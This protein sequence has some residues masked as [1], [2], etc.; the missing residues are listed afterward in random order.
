MDHIHTC[1]VGAG[2]VGLAIARKLASLGNEVVVLDAEQHYGQ[3]VS[4]RN[5]EVIHAGIYY[6]KDSSKA[7]FCVAGKELLYDYCAS[8]G[9]AADRCGKIIVATSSVE[10]AELETIALKARDNG[11]TD[12]EVWSAE[13]IRQEEPQVNATIGLH[14][15][16]SGIVDT[17]GLMSAM[18]GDLENS[19]GM[20]VG[21]TR[22]EAVD[23]PQDGFIVQSRVAGDE[24]RFSCRLLVNA[25]GLGAQAVAAGIEGLDP[26]T[27][28]ALYYCK[29]SYFTLTSGRPFT[30]LIYPVPEK[31]G[32]G[33]GV[34]ATIDLGGQC[35]FGPDVEYVNEADYAVDESKRDLFLESVQRY[36]PSLEADDLV[37]GYAGIRPKLQGP[38]DLPQDFVIQDE[39][40]HGIPGLVQLFGIESPGLTSSLA[41]AEHV[42]T[43]SVPEFGMP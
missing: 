2:V 29:G 20:F 26:D 4:S 8:R 30:R 13:K 42:A 34:H 40:D 36:F 41:I 35:K 37:P 43:L 17:H 14:S 21:G 1:V 10:E 31:S 39:R 28:P 32:A 25:A 6:P 24:Y 27:I 15:P 22:V 7:R 11:V 16:S 38:D 23:R 18:L 3:G 12:L 5:S 9:V 33:L 19:G